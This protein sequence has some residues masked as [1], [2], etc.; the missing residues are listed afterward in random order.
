MKAACIEAVQAALG[1][2]LGAAEAKGIEAG[3]TLQMKLLA[4]KD[5]SA[6]RAMSSAEQMGQAARAAADAMVADVKKQQQRLLLTI[7]AHDRIENFLNREAIKGMTKPGDK[8]RALSNVLDF[9]TKGGGFTSAGSWI[10]ALQQQTFAHLIDLWSSSHPKFFGLFED[11]AGTR[12]LV[13]EMWGEKT[14]NAAAKAGAKAWA[15]AMEELRDRYNA[16]G[17]N[18]G[19]LDEWHFPQ[20]HSQTRVAQAGLA[21]WL[22]DLMP[23]LDRSKYLHTDGTQMTDPEV[24]KLMTGAHDSITTDGQNKIDTS[25]PQGYGLTAGR[26][27]E[28]R[29]V[30]YKDA[31]SFLAYQGLYGE[32]SLWNVLTSHVRSL[33]RDVGLAEVMGPDPDRVFG[34]FNQR[35]YL[36]EL[37]ANPTAKSKLD[38]A[39]VFNDK[40][41]D[42]VSGRQQVVDTDL[43]AKF[44]GFRNFYRNHE[45][46]LGGR[47]LAVRDAVQELFVLDD[48]Q[49]L[50]ARGLDAWGRIQ[51][52]LHGPLDHLRRR[53]RRP[54][55]PAA[56]AAGGK[57][58]REHGE[59]QVLDC[60]APSR[61][62]T[63]VLRGLPLRRVQLERQQ[64]RGGF[65]RPS[66]DHRRGCVEAHRRRSYPPHQGRA[67]GRGR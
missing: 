27:G 33:A 19:K 8:M 6:W 34:A 12:D 61:R 32:S 63:G 39:K 42:Y 45:G 10:H 22:N 58:S 18:V 21:R 30:F 14:G 60:R 23:L 16:A 4:R 7:A 29:V 59:S 24:R 57:G 3:I 25:R 26:G 47:A 48:V 20:H 54:G 64:P 37:R 51:V 5:P 13:R 50:D 35:T 11:R 62:G 49:A 1:R 9:D 41:L 31:N 67:D 66:R 56:R 28:H 40:L 43:A 17:G 2:G 55:Q 46:D 52:R 36:E 44:Q 15:Q 65:C 53:A 38:K